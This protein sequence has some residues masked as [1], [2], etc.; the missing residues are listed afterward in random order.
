M[1]AS[2]NQC[3][4]FEVNLNDLDV[5][6]CRFNRDRGNSNSDFGRNNSSGRGSRDGF[7]RDGPSRGMGGGGGGGGGGRFGG[8]GGNAFR[9]DDNRSSDRRGDRF[10]S[11]MDRGFSGNRNQQNQGPGENLRRVRWEDYSLIPF[12][13]NF[14]SPCESVLLRTEQEIERFQRKNEITTKGKDVPPPLLE[15]YEGKFPDYAMREITKCGFEKPT[16]IQA[17]GIVSLVRHLHRL[18]ESAKLNRS[19]LQFV[20]LGWPIALSGRDMVGIA[21]T[22][23]GKTLAYIMPAVV[24][25]NHQPRLQRGDGPIVLV[26][27]PTREL[28]QQI[29]QVANDF[30]S[31]TQIKN[32]W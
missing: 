10:G 7:S 22:G 14:Y 32:T 30:G 19:T 20:I 4:N 5:Q 2:C 1:L 29:Q 13:K 9:R 8:N 12:Q 26:L 6:C 16:P 18:L 21:Q 23:S 28:A 3:V 27:A 25:I 15:F 31:C 24:H 11:N 17:Q